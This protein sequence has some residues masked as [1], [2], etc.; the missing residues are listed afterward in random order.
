MKLIEIA[1]NY[2]TLY[3]GT[4]AE[5]EKYDKRFLKTADH[6]YTTPDPNTASNY[7]KNV[8]VVRA[9]LGRVADLIDDY[10]VI[11]KVA[12]EVAYKFEDSVKYLDS[13][14]D[15]QDH[16][17][18]LDL[19]DDRIEEYLDKFKALVDQEEDFDD[20][21]YTDEYDD[22]VEEIA[23]LEA[24]QFIQSGK[25]YDFDS[26]G[27]FQGEVIDTALAMDYDCVIIHDHSSYGES[28][29]YVFDDPNRLQF[30]EKYED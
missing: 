15:V 21:K 30:V 9:D 22:L 3:H 11:G 13:L 10:A 26:S 7:G 8:Y 29:S 20:I 25:M 23:T 4:D 28:V 19:D 24:T 5:F 16:L 14:E 2:E 27:R 18:Y 6:I 17:R 12:K 1:N